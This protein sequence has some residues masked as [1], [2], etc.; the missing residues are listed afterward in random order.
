MRSFGLIGKHLSHS[1]SKILFEK[2]WNNKKDVSYDLFE[3]KQI[4]D[5]L[6]LIDEN[7]SLEG[8]NVTIPY[9]KA[10]IPFLDEIEDTALQIQSVNCVQIQRQ[11]SKKTYLKGFNTDYL[12]FYQSFKPMLLESDK[13]ALILGT[14][15][16][17]LT[18]EYALKQM[19]IE[20]DFVSRNHPKALKYEDLKN[21]INK[22]S[23]IVNCTPVG[24]FPEVEARLNFPYEEITQKHFIYDLIYNPEETFLIKMAKKRQSRF[25][26]GIKMLTLQAI[27]SWE[28]WNI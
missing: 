20:C 19:N 5:V 13:K 14:G 18:V 16:A 2:E 15:G 21:Q 3:L 23:I 25:Q 1:Y 4:Q 22:Y 12:A 7:H 27:N 26:N 8:F 9:K 28:I 10:I 6:P 24:M 17:S 11:S